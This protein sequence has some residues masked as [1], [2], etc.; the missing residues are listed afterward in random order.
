VSFCWPSPAPVWTPQNL[1]ELWRAFVGRPE[2]GSRSF[3]DK[4]KDQLAESTEEVHRVAVD[5]LVLYCMFP[6]NIG[7][8]AKLELISTVVG[9]KLSQDPPDYEA[10]GRIFARGVGDAG[11]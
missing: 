9:W 3:L 11:V 10:L 1:E 6:T 8:D 4:F 7:K 5:I 2:L